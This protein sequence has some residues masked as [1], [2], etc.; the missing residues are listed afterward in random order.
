LAAF[1]TPLLRLSSYGLAFT[2][3]SNLSLRRLALLEL[4]T[5]KKRRIAAAV[6]RMS[7]RYK[8]RPENIRVRLLDFWRAERGRRGFSSL[9][10]RRD[11]DELLRET[12]VGRSIT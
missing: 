1:L 3:P 6:Q 7:L 11:I 8:E 2:K 5:K 12:N 4:S 9:E 10:S